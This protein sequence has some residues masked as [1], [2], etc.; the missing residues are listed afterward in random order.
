MV[1]CEADT[2][3]C[4]LD[5]TC[6]TGQSEQVSGCMLTYT[7]DGGSSQSVVSQSGE[8]TLRVAVPCD[9][10]TIFYQGQ[11]L[12]QTMTLLEC[13]HIGTAKCPNMKGTKLHGTV[14]TFVYM[15]MCLPIYL[16]ALF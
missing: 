8:L 7:S 3:S 6:V 5:V 4:Y 9:A 16:Y 14:N 1:S 2:D 13:R 10:Q 15:C 11:F 12:S